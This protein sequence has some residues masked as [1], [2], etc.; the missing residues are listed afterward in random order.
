MHPGPF[1]SLSFMLCSHEMSTLLYHTFPPYPSA[2]PQT[3]IQQSVHHIRQKNKNKNKTSLKNNSLVYVYSLHN[4]KLPNTPSFKLQLLQRGFLQQW[5][6]C[7]HAILPISLCT[8]R[9]SRPMNRTR[10]K[11]GLKIRKIVLK[12]SFSQLIYEYRI[13][14]MLWIGP[15]VSTKCLTLLCL[16]SQSKLK[17]VSFFQKLRT[18]GILQL[19]SK[20][21]SAH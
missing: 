16:W 11:T 21:T 3:R 6:R 2:S 5:H 1:T 14:L 8:V 12:Y 18:L 13:L 15:F 4:G 17:D 7:N 10:L 19:R 9:S 20:D